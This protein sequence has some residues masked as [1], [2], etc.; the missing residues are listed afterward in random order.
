MATGRKRDSLQTMDPQHYYQVALPSEQSANQYF[1]GSQ[2]GRPQQ[3]DVSPMQPQLLPDDWAQMGRPVLNDS[4]LMQTCSTS[5]VEPPLKNFDE[6]YSATPEETQRDIDNSKLPPY[7]AE[8]FALGDA[9]GS[10]VNRR[11]E[12]ICR[13]TTHVTKDTIT[14]SY[15]PNVKMLHDTCHGLAARLLASEQRAARLEA[16]VE[17]FTTLLFGSEDP[18]DIQGASEMGGL[19]VNL[20]DFVTAEAKAQGVLKR[21]AAL[22]LKGRQARRPCLDS[23]MYE[24]QRSGRPGPRDVRQM[25]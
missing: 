7:P 4:P 18:P 25:M 17:F 8:I 10:L 13:L 23:M 11:F 6:F 14:R 9:I 20:S 21:L 3:I 16:H 24:Q 12:S 19:R 15:L 2:V 22:D 1:D 5:D